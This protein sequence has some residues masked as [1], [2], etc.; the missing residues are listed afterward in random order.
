MF[1]NHGAE[2]EH[3]TSVDND[4]Y[5]A[6]KRMLRA[7]LT[8]A[9]LDATRGTGLS[10]S[11]ARAWLQSKTYQGRDSLTFTFAATCEY[12]G[13]SS[14]IRRRILDLLLLDAPKVRSSRRQVL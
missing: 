2:S 5:T 11:Q 9:I 10:Q 8:R 13:L 4:E 6:E 1:L 3:L 12:L 7:L 14:T